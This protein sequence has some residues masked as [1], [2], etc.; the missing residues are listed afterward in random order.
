MPKKKKLEQP[1]IKKSFNTVLELFHSTPIYFKDLPNAKELNQYLLKHEN[2][3]TICLLFLNVLLDLC[4][5]T[6]IRF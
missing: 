1:E 4:S 6:I 3:H 2:H 5:L